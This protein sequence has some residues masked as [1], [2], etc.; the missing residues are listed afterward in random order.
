MSLESTL[1]T[2]NELLAQV[3]TILQTGLQA[4]ATFGEPEVKQ[5][6]TRKT[7]TEAS[8]E[9]VT[10]ATSTQQT[11]HTADETGPG[12]VE[13][14]TESQYFIVERHNTVFEVKPGEKNPQVAGSARISK[15]VYEAKKAEFAKKT[16][17]V[18][19]Q[20]ATAAPTTAPAA[21]PAPTTPDASTASSQQ[22]EQTQAEVPFKAI[23]DKVT[24][25]LKS[26]K[27]GQGRPAV[28]AILA[29]W[30]PGVEGP[31]VTKMQA[32][33]KNAE[34]LADIEAALA[35]PK[36]DEFDLLG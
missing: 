22:S 15:E 25:L 10:Q 24:V 23:I 11:T 1:Q 16:T 29:K 17:E 21:A 27:P 5:T 36:A 8:P 31:T 3:I 12:V 13:S 7:K 2:T 19:N 33:G 9:V 18:L 32:L 28:Q 4:P 30:L 34:I 20:S 14:D 26:D 35:E 6:R